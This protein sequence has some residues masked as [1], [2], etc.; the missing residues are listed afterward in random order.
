MALGSRILT[1]IAIG[2]VSTALTSTSP[3]GA[4]HIA[5]RVGYQERYFTNV[6]GES[7]LLRAWMNVDYANARIRAYAESFQDHPAQACVRAVLIEGGVSR[8]IGTRVCGSGGTLAYTNLYTCPGARD[9]RSRNDTNAYSSRDSLYDVYE[10]Y[11][12]LTQTTCRH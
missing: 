8:V 4:T 3:A 2:V 7:A 9:F 5:E 11:S 1:V 10:L 6:Y 12:G